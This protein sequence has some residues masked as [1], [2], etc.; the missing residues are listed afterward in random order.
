[1]RLENQRRLLRPTRSLKF[2]WTYNVTPLPSPVCGIEYIQQQR[3]FGFRRAVELPQ[4]RSRILQDRS[5][6]PEEPSCHALNRFL[7]EKVY[8]EEDRESNAARQFRT[9]KY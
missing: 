8:I 2:E 7:R 6:Q 4:A 5:D 3:F 1:M 9:G